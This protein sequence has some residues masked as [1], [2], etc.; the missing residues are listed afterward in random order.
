MSVTDSA[1]TL[2]TRGVT[3]IEE[4][5]EAR[6]RVLGEQEF[7]RA[8]EAAFYEAVPTDP[9]DDP[10]RLKAGLGRFLL[11]QE[12]RA[13]ELLLQVKDELAAFVRARIWLGRGDAQRAL[14]EVA[15]VVAK[16]PDSLA[17]RIVL[18]EAYA[19]LGDAAGLE[20]ESKE[21]QKSHGDSP[22][23]TYVQGL[24]KELEGE[25]DQA[26]RL[27]QQTLAVEPGHTGALFRLAYHES[28][29][30]DPETAIELYERL[31]N[32]NPAPIGALLNLGLLF[33]DDEDDQLAQN[34][35][36]KILDFD[37][38][39]PRARLYLAD[40]SASAGQ[41]Y[42]EEKK[43]NE[44]KHA[45]VLSIPVTDFELSV[46]ARNCLAN[47][48][49][50]TLGDLISLS[51]QDLLAYKNFGETS[52][53]EIKQILVQKGLR[54][55]M[56]APKPDLGP[57]VAEPVDR[58]QVVHKPVNELDLSVRSRRA[59]DTLG[60]RSVGELANLTE[61]Q[62]LACKNFGQTSLQEIKKKLESLGLA[63]RAE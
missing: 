3:T 37:P 38:N 46:R 30:G 42:D 5:E 59:L 56:A 20:R 49:V 58:V 8:Y 52:L 9:S 62:L 55:G 39:H 53:T 24:L 6:H 1:P 16:R 51:E 48:N 13:L 45:A 33:E 34:C 61:A 32:V 60:V 4:L 23:A 2:A 36:Q 28:L 41:F 47:M 57:R 31:C 12:S 25:Y 11:G 50:R 29:R 40:V 43:R 44:D 15:D 19:Q 22:S 63:L 54:L 14:K 10:S 17:A 18:S 21:V 26:V 7:Y 27:W 35:F